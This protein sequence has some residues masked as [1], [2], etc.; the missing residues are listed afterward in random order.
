MTNVA[1]KMAFKQKLWHRLKALDLSFLKE[2]VIL[3]ENVV[4]F[5]YEQLMEG[6]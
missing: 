2:Q 1:L 3:A 6:R 4:V 5:S